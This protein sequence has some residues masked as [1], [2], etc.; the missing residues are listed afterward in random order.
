MGQGLNKPLW[1]ALYLALVAW[2]YAPILS[3]GPFGADLE[4][5]AGLSGR[6]SAALYTVPHTDGRPLAALSLF[7]SR[8]LWSAER[9]WPAHLATWLRLENLICL[10]IAAQGL[11]LVLQRLFAPW[12]GRETARAAALTA[13]LLLMVHPLPVAAVSMVHLRGELLALAFGTFGLAAFLEAR[14]ERNKRL[15]GRAFLFAFLAGMCG[16]WALFLPFLYCVLEGVSSQRHRPSAARWRSAGMTFVAC[17]V[18]VAA[19][20][21]LRGQLAPESARTFQYLSVHLSA[22][23]FTVEKL[24]VLFMPA[25]VGS[26]GVLAIPVAL[27]TLIL[28]THPGFVAARSAPRLWGRIVA[29]WGVSL[30][31]SLILDADQRVVSLD[32]V[33]TQVL[34][35]ATL[36][37][38]TGWGL[39]ATA[40]SDF[41]RTL[42]PVLLLLLFA[43]LA[44]GTAE[45]IRQASYQVD[46]LRTDLEQAA[47]RRNFRGS[48]VL[49]EP[50][51]QVAGHQIL[52]SDP[53]VLLS[54]R[55]AQ[56]A[57][58]R[59]PEGGPLVRAI[60]RPA[61]GGWWGSPDFFTRVEE[62]LCFLVPPDLLGL[63]VGPLMAF[64]VPIIEGQPFVLEL[65]GNDFNGANGSP[66]GDGRLVP[67]W[68][69][70]LTVH[71][72]RGRQVSEAPKIEW[73][74]PGG[75]LGS[76]KG[77][78]VRST[79]PDLLEARFDLRAQ[80]A[81]VF[82]GWLT[83]LRAVG[84]LAGHPLVFTSE[85][86]VLPAGVM[87]HWSSE[88]WIVNTHGFEVPS[89]GDV[90]QGADSVPEWILWRMSP[91][92]LKREEFV[93][94]ALDA[95][96]LVAQIP[97]NA[98]HESPGALVG[99]WGVECRLDG[100]VIAAASG[101]LQLR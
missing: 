20:F 51:Q 21:V 16:R 28:A 80:P 10:A 41:R 6:G 75:L 30:A 89:A 31:L 78:W 46:S 84:P 38:C 2:A 85:P 32:L 68:Y 35:G 11:R 55:L 64:D 62:G 45:P 61:L 33:G 60:D 83:K 91:G 1:V 13:G 27:A 90:E 18:C 23:P 56:G 77:V 59:V 71:V 26:V 34:L 98:Q 101:L 44:H 17:A 8:G 37:L 99:L 19:E 40:I 97:S 53:S 36:I 88:G 15:L 69:T 73:Q 3:A 24:G 67:A 29:V 5:L 94:E 65:A 25:P 12:F 9:V 96:R 95:E 79:N 92:V 93:L 50:K 47:G 87:P 22:I 48:Y 42:L 49:L 70:Q 66:I 72:P 54:R 81:W 43:W 76:A 4:L 58:G 14:Q 100:V 39:A 82:A 63:E 86:T 7:L 57:W 52:P 74:A